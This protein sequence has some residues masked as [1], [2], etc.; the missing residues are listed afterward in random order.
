MSH[1]NHKKEKTKHVYTGK[2]LAHL[3]STSIPNVTRDS[4]SSPDT[5]DA[6]RRHVIVRIQT[7]ATAYMGLER[8]FS[9]GY[10]R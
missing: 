6:I 8:I 10:S 7:S 2:F 1:F 4:L 9:N 3:F 5:D